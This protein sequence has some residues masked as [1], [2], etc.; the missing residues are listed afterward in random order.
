MKTTP[1]PDFHSGTGGEM[2]RNKQ[3]TMMNRVKTHPM[4]PLLPHF[5]LER[6]GLTR[7]VIPHERRGIVLRFRIKTKVRYRIRWE[8]KLLPFP[9]TPPDGTAGDY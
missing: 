5:M 9:P 6:I 1:A 3:N 8:V 2:V 4:Q 7:K